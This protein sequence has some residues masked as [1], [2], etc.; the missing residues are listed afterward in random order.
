MLDIK[1]KLVFMF[2]WYNTMFIVRSK[3]KSSSNLEQ[4]ETIIICDV[5]KSPRAARGFS[6]QPSYNH[7]DSRTFSILIIWC[8]GMVSLCNTNTNV[9]FLSG[10][11]AN[12]LP[13]TLYPPWYRYHH[14]TI[15][16]S[17]SGPVTANPDMVVKRQCKSWCELSWWTPR[18]RPGTTAAP[19]SSVPQP[20]DQW[21]H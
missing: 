8:S 7:K 6:Y 19:V 15:M 9:F 20:E 12:I 16:A 3:S 21:I 1:K 18:A 13:G 10:C 2:S 4:I 14:V 5:Y 11:G 17:T